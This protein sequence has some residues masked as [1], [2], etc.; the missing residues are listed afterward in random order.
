[1]M[2]DFLRDYLLEKGFKFLGDKLKKNQNKKSSIGN[3]EHSAKLSN[4]S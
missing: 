1:M 4:L 3:E 2:L